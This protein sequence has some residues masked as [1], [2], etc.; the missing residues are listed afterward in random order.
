MRNVTTTKPTLMR[1]LLKS[2]A[3]YFT[4]LKTPSHIYLSTG[5]MDELIISAIVLHIWDCLGM[6]RAIVYRFLV[7]L[8]TPFLGV[9]IINITM[10]Y[11]S[12][13]HLQENGREAVVS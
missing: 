6:L 11:V 3:M 5:A 8:Y 2:F 9:R 10:E 13:L 7:Y 1:A 12:T 4:L